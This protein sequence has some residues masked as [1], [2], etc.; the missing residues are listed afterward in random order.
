MIFGRSRPNNPSMASTFR[1]KGPDCAGISVPS[2][3]FFPPGFVLC[4]GNGRRCASCLKNVCAH[5]IFV[6]LWAS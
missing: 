1:K 2:V 3:S 6:A 5:I 4:V